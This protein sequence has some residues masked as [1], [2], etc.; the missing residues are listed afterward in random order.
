MN[1]EIIPDPAHPLGGHALLILPEGA[2]V[3]SGLMIMRKRDSGQHL[4]AGGWQAAPTT[5]GPFAISPRDGG[6]AVA[7]GPDVVVHLA[8]FEQIEIAFEGAPRVRRSGPTQS[9]CHPM[10]RPSA[11]CAQ[12]R[13]QRVPARPRG[14]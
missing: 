4:G 14:R 3:G 1:F 5:L 13:R 12:G 2:S 6:H 9:S 7:L 8:E 11:G 10:W